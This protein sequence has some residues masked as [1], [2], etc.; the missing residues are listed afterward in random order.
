MKK[1]FKII[2]SRMTLVIVAI[3]L[4]LSISL[5]LPY[6]I[7]HY[8]PLVIN[9]IFIPLEI[10]LGVF[11]FVLVVRVIN[12]DMTIEGQLVW[13]ILF[14]SFPLFGIM[15][16]FLFVRRH[17]PPKHKKYFKVA[18]QKIIEC[19]KRTEQEV[20]DLKSET[21]E[22]FGQF[23]YIYKTTGMKT[24]KNTEV[25]Y[26]HNGDIFLAELLNSLEKATR[27]I[28][29]EYFIIE[30]GE[31]WNKILNVLKK[32]VKQGVEVRLM[33][34]DLGSINKLPNNYA[35]KLNQ[36][37][38]KCVKFNSFLPIISAVHNNRDH[39]KITIVDGKVGFVSGLNIADEYVNI[40][41]KYGYWKDTAVRIKGDAVKN[42]LYMFLPLYNVQ[43][44]IEED[45]NKYLPNE[46]VTINANGYVC[47]YGDGPKYFIKDYV[48]L[49]VYLNMI[50]QAKNYIW[51]TT[52]YLIIDNK[53][54]N[55]LCT[56]AKRG[57]DVR[58]ITPH[59]PDKKFIFWLTR[60]T[61]KPLK[62][63][64]VKIY[65]YEKGFIHAKQ[66]ICDDKIGIVGTINFDYRSLLHHYE[67]G[68]LMYNVPALKAI[69]KDFEHMF[70]ISID[71]KDYKQNPCARLLCA[72][73]KIFTPML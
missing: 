69:K 40:V 49:N 1:F 2:F 14:L 23:E 24:Y 39:R 31:M 42:L 57:V 19:T 34:D 56:A 59:T 48:S 20:K 61:Y 7:N 53:L 38:I 70:T 47:P 43:A 4:Q 60:S 58:I 55:A 15:I 17:E 44:Q 51:I 8:Y 21:G 29:M 5:V 6:V 45:Y 66:V 25:K 46:V 71:M 65:E 52:P 41:Q 22:Y 9:N 62:E 18:K 50:N 35:K 64:G 68:V 28:F 37:G 54:L 12:S 30:R 63:A 26:L 13:V 11:A 36:M 72:I 32:K 27:Y 73:A 67:C 3:L 16:Y 33:Y 10:V